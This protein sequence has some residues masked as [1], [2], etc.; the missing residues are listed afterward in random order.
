V[1]TEGAS[2][3]VADPHDALGDIAAGEGDFSLGIRHGSILSELFCSLHPKAEVE[4]ATWPK[5][6]SAV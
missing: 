4:G 3:G 2:D 1:R 5:S 6:R